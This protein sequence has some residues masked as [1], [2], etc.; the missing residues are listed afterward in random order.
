MLTRFGFKRPQNRARGC[1]QVRII[2]RPLH[3]LIDGGTVY[4]SLGTFFLIFIISA[5]WRKQ[6]VAKLSSCDT[7]VDIIG[8]SET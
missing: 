8:H 6:S 7:A 5:G 4:I 3:R 2:P 1:N